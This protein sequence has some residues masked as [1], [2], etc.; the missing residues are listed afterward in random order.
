M[1]KATKVFKEAGLMFGGTSARKKFGE[2]MQLVSFFA[3]F[4][5]S[6]LLNLRSLE[7]QMFKS[8][9]AHFYGQL[10]SRMPYL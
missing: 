5:D 6:R 10:H 8:T 2:P 4:L 1:A 9:F 7:R 3:A